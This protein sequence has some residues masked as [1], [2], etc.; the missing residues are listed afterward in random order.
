MRTLV[1][2]SKNLEEDEYK[3]WKWIYTKAMTDLTNQKQKKKEAEE[4]ME[5]DMVV[6]GATAIED[7]L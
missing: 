6:I 2:A 4:M 3:E 1:L 5:K 7:K